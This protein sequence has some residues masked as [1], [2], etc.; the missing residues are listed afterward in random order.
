[1]KWAEPDILNEIDREAE[2]MKARIRG[3]GDDLRTAGTTYYVAADGSDDHDGRDAGHAWKSLEKVSAAELKPGDCVRFRRG[4]VFRGQI[5]CR[6]GVTY[7]AFGEGAKPA[8]YGWKRDLADPDLWEAVDGARHVFR[9]REKMPD[10][11]ALVFDHGK[12]HTR[13]L[14]PSWIDGRFVCREDPERAFVVAEEM[15]GDLDLFC[16]CAAVMTNAPSHGETWPVPHMCDGNRGDLYLRCDAGNPGAVFDSIEAL[17]GRNT[18]VVGAAPDVHIDNLCIKYCGAHAI[19]AGG[20]CVRGLRVTRCEIGWVGGTIQHYLGIDPNYPE[21]TR[22]SVTR[23]GNGIEIYGGCDGFLCANNY[24]Y[25]VYDAGVTHQYTVPE[26]ESCQ[27]RNIR[28]TGN[29][30]E[31]CVYSIEY[32]LSNTGDGDSLMDGV[33]IDHNLLRFSGCGWGQQRHNIWTPAHIKSWTF[34]NPARNY[35]IHDNIFDR[36]RYRLLH[37]CCADRDSYPAIDHN[38]YIQTLGWT[39]GQFGE[40]AV[41]PPPVL[42]F[43][44]DAEADIAE[45]VGD[46]HASVYFCK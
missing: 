30:I 45:R 14:I 1:M 23:F 27:M 2:R 9:L 7:A 3:A 39:L 12:R 44:E 24:I 35:S 29:L 11:G 25:Q 8:I 16:D 10:C 22:G 31:N 41:A 46:R 34:E 28:Y 19:G 26:G 36:A 18:V 42:A 37:L 4:D 21:G 17:P 32:F 20:N 43:T 33:E 15:T 6:A 5:L 40:D 13:K 38:T